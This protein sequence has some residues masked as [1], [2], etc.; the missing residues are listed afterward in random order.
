MG[1]LKKLFSPK[2]PEEPEGP[3]LIEKN[4]LKYLSNSDEPYNGEWINILP[5]YT[6]V[7]NYKNGK[8][9]GKQIEYDNNSK[10]EQGFTVQVLGRKNHI[11][12]ETDYKNGRKH[13][14]EITRDV[15]GNI[16]KENIYK[17]DK[18]IRSTTFNKKG[19]KNIEKVLEKGKFKTVYRKPKA[20][21]KA[22]PKKKKINVKWEYP[23]DMWT[24]VATD[25]NNW[26]FELS[27][28]PKHEIILEKARQRLDYAE[29]FISQTNE[30]IEKYPDERKHPLKSDIEKIIRDTKKLLQGI[31]KKRINILLKKIIELLKERG[32]KMPASDIDAFLKHQ[33]VDEIKELCEQMYHNGEIS[34][35][36]NYRYFILSEE[37]KKP[38]KAA[39]KKSKPRKTSAPKTDSVADEIKKFADLKDQG[40][41]TQE[42]F[43]AKKK[44]LLGL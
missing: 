34:R 35:T 5:N 20:K 24:E 40:I 9:D 14:K 16:I 2:E 43:D 8:M 10:D 30:H 13:G 29:Q 31:E 44:E 33:D 38:K 42:E 37:K 1:L 11:C 7:E 15:D 6:I 21:P 36:A 12:T 23:D 17:N 3:K 22:K 27:G 19:E 32:E 28:G 25:L 26:I 39:A 41:L 18:L 4:G